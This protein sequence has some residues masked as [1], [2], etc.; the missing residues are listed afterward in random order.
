MVYGCS[1]DKIHLCVK[2]LCMTIVTLCVCV[3]ARA[4]ARA[5]VCVMCVARYWSGEFLGGMFAGWVQ[6]RVLNN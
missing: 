1:L 6:H 2:P 5:C 3:Y 4:R